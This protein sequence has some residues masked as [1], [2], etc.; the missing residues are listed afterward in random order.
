MADKS[1]DGLVEA[2]IMQGY[3]LKWTNYMKGF[4]RRYFVL[5]RGILSYYRFVLLVVHP[6]AYLPRSA[7]H[8]PFRLILERP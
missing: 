2:P 4:Q 7:H 6:T 5:E 3:L 8:E 1:L